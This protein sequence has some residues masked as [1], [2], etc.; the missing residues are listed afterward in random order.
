[1]LKALSISSQFMELKVDSSVWRKVPFV[2]QVV[3]MRR[4]C[5][6][7]RM[8][9][10]GDDVTIPLEVRRRHRWKGGKDE[11]GLGVWWRAACAV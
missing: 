5:M 1:M 2:L 7:L 4:W 6:C 11:E 3:M 9:F 8:A 10:Q